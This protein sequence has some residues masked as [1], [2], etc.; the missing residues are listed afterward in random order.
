MSKKE[1]ILFS[2]QKFS[3]AISEI[4]VSQ[5]AKSMAPNHHQ[6]TQIEVD[7]FN[8]E[9]DIESIVYDIGGEGHI[10]ASEVD[11]YKNEHAQERSSH[12]CGECGHIM[13]CPEAGEKIASKLAYM[14][15]VAIPFPEV[16]SA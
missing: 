15:S 5:A 8:T 7:S 6:G 14:P 13:E 10:I 11:A 1:L 12:L 3:L 16:R 4:R 2:G 9:E